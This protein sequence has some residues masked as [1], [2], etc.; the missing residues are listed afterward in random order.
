MK[1]LLIWT[2][3]LSQQLTWY[4][5]YERGEKHFKKGEY[6][7]C[8]EDMDEAL[9][10]NPLPQRNQFTRAVQKIDYKPFY[11]KALAYFQL[12]DLPSAYQNAQAAFQGDVV[13]NSP[14]LQSDLGEI[15]QAYRSYVQDFHQRFTREQTV[16]NERNRLLEL[17]RDNRLADVKAELD[18]LD[19]LAGFEDIITNLEIQEEYYRRLSVFRGDVLRQIED[20]LNKGEAERARELFDTLK[21]SLPIETV[22]M[23]ER[24]FQAAPPEPPRPQSQDEN[25]AEDASPPLV[26]YPA[27]IEDFNL[28]LKSLEAQNAESGRN[29]NRVQEQNRALQDQL[30]AKQQGPAPF[31]PKLLLEL[32]RKGFDQILIEGHAVSPMLVKHWLLALNGKALSI[33]GSALVEEGS[34]FHLDHAIRAPFFGEHTVR[35]SLVDETGNRVFTEKKILV[36]PP[37]YLKPRF[38]LFSGI[39]ILVLI[40]LLLTVQAIRRKRARLRHFNPY[41]AGSPVRAAAMFYGRD[42][43][44]QRIQGLVHKNSFMIHGDRRI[45]K[46]SLLLQLQK[47]LA[48]LESESYRFYP[49]F[50]DLQGVREEDLFHHMMA[51]LLIQAGDWEISLDGLSFREEAEGY[52]SRHFSK[53]IKKLI[54]RLNQ[55]NAKH[56]VVVL[57]VD[58]V[59]V[60]NEFGEKT[61]Q[62][63]RGIFMKDFAEHLSCVMAGIHLKK[64]WESSGSPWYNFFEEIPVTPFDEAYARDLILE[65]VKGIFKYKPNAVDLIIRQTACHPYLIQKVCVSVIGEKLKSNRFVISR[66]DVANALTN[67]R[68][69]MKRNQPS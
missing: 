29:L 22:D 42:E 48:E 27:I 49:A 14:L 43:L 10:E 13:A 18:G 67:M 5:V 59:D 68:Q 57:L 46:T 55:A 52:Q 9:A 50:L 69:E 63:L 62:K 53:D 25:G 1:P 7:R 23:L 3:V 66:A 65:P 60:L 61:N 19:S 8:I 64:E 47:N 17:L 11:Y 30:R 51:E 28:R 56:V 44:M 34:D 45:G 24:R 20:W 4:E 33:P 54:Q 58:E 31:L 40:L 38:W 35:F 15:L 36:P 26:D 39:G 41:I 16:I 37:I 2:L 32:K 12:G 6:Q 21:D